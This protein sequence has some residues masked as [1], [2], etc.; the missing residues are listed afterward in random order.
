M[1]LPF[2]LR[3]K[4]VDLSPAMV[5]E[6]RSQA[7]R[8]DHFF[9]RVMRCRVTI[10]GPGNHH[11]Q[12]L[13]RVTVDVTIPRAQIVVHKVES[14]SME[15]AFGAAFDA[16]IRCL[17]DHVDRMRGFVKTKAVSRT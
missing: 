13:Y 1:K 3:Q 14:S 10:E 12:G 6:I 11:R 8:L 16:T 4:N 9:D 15:L 7:E 5:E 17:E 2:E